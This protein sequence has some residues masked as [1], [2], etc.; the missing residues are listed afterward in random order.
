MSYYNL[1]NQTALNYYV[2]H[3]QR[4]LDLSD[5]E[6][7][8]NHFL[9]GEK[10]NKNEQKFSLVMKELLC[11]DNCELINY[12][13][14]KLSGK[15]EPKLRHLKTV[16]KTNGGHITYNVTQVIRENFNWSDTSW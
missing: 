11:T 3:R 2:K 14:D 5:K 4:L 15:L 1:Y 7:I 8:Y 6:Y 10:I 16:T 12:I 13:N 9:V